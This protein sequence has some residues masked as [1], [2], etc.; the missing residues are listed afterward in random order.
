MLT[1]Y[2][3]TL[4]D[5]SVKKIDAVRNGVWLH[6]ESSTE[7][8]V[9]QLA[10]NL[11]LDMGILEDAQDFYEVPRLERSDGVTYFFTRYPY[12][13]QK[14]D[15]D[16]APLL[17]VMGDNFVLTVAQRPVPQFDSIISGKV[18][19]YT[20]Q[21]TKLFIIM[22]E[23]ITQLFERQL[24]TLRRSV[25]KD[26]VNLSK[27][28]SKEIVRFVNYE[29]RLNDMV[30]AV[31]PTNVAIQQ[32]MGG[33][34]VQVID[35]DKEALDD[36]RIDNDQVL[37]SARILLKTIQNVRSASEAILASSLNTRIKTLTVLTILLTIPMVIASLYGMNVTLPL[38]SHPDAFMYVVGS[39]LAAVGLMVW[40]FRKNDWL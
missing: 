18:T 37:E 36:L 25:L 2:F 39:V 34:Y 35:D 4:K 6:A 7:Q 11:G 21:K 8:D 27:I 20:T 14:E 15:I 5:D 13:E 30:A 40:Y 9:Q 19:A 33:K 38:E 28:G 22:M 26:R 24:I 32:I 16:T 31:L 10:D 3:R 1:N 23:L 29:H 17:I 12:N